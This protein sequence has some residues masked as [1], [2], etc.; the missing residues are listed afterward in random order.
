[1][2]NKIYAVI[3]GVILASLTSFLTHENAFYNLRFH[4]G[5]Y[6]RVSE[7]K[8]IEKTLRLFNRYFA[9]FFSTGGSLEGLNEFPAANLIKRRIF[10]E[11]ND[12][13]KEGYLLVYDRDV[14]KIESVEMLDPISAVA[15]AKEVWFL[16]VQDLNTRRYVSPVKA[17]PIRVRYF[18]EK[19]GKKWQV[20]EYE[21]FGAQDEIPPLDERRA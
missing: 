18:L 6:D 12:W 7:E 2:K 9:T 21:V 10:Q 20:V 8:D 16:N 15:I 4:L 3:V 19:I 5:L 1:M 13:K 14:F 11:I 17:D